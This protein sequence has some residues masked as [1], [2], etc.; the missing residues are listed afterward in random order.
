M[1]EMGQTQTVPV[2][3]TQP[4]ARRQRLSGRSRPESAVRQVANL[5]LLAVVGAGIM[6]GGLELLDVMLDLLAT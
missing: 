5:A 2:R 6:F 3:R 4:V 1:Y